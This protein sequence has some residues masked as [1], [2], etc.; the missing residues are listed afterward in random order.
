MREVSRQAG[1]GYCTR[2]ASP[3]L[4]YWLLMM[5]GDDVIKETLGSMGYYTLYRPVATRKKNSECRLCYCII[6][7]C[8]GPYEESL[9]SSLLYVLPRLLYVSQPLPCYVSLPAMLEYS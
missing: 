2:L 1:G 3:R 4:L 8:G 6:A 5:W 7:A 9:M